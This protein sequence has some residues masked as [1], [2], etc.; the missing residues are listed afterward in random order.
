MFEK[1]R[2]LEQL[3]E[4]IKSLETARSALADIKS[5][6]AVLRDAGADV[7]DLRSQRR[8]ARRA[9]DSAGEGVE[10]ARALVEAAILEPPVAEEPPVVE[11]PI[12]E[13][14]VSEEPE[15]DEPSS[16]EEPEVDE[17]PS[18]PLDEEPE[19]PEPPPE[20]LFSLEDQHAVSK[21]MQDSAVH[22]ATKRAQ[23]FWEIRHRHTIDGAPSDPIRAQTIAAAYELYEQH[24]IRKADFEPF[25]PRALSPTE[26]QALSDFRE[27]ATDNPRSVRWE[28]TKT[29]VDYLDRNGHHAGGNK[30][31]VEFPPGEL[32]GPIEHLKSQLG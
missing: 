7:S 9:I 18:E 26:Q 4:A 24:V 28:V 19:A 30:D 17:V 5:T 13:P 15:V 8:E 29:E 11:P 31:T 27:M 16:P 22:L 12:E 23:N 3:D 6:I 1:S 10:A 20:D 25:E 14:T 32:V 2:T 21:L